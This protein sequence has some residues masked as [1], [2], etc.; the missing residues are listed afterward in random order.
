MADYRVEFMLDLSAEFEEAPVLLAELGSG[1]ELAAVAALF[2]T[3]PC[4]VPA[5]TLTTIWK[6]AVSRLAVDGLE[7]ITF[8]VPPGDGVF[9]VHPVPLVTEADTNV[10]FEGTGS[11]TVVLSPAPGP[12]LMKLIV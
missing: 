1:I 11:V 4:A 8:P 9:V 7:K 12:L 10:V 5:L 2:I 3:V 6:V